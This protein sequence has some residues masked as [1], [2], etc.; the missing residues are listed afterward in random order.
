MAN[1]REPWKHLFACRVQNPVPWRVAYLAQQYLLPATWQLRGFAQSR[2]R[3]L[4]PKA[5]EKKHPFPSDRSKAR[6][7]WNRERVPSRLRRA[8]A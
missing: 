8:L 4:G 1:G 7:Y 6:R 3:R 2:H 5:A